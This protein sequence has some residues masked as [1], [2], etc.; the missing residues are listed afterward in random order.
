MKIARKT[1][2]PRILALAISAM[3]SA[4]TNWS[5]TMTTTRSSVN[6]NAWLKFVSLNIVRNGDSVQS[7]PIRKASSNACTI[8]HAKKRPR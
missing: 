8:G 7:S 2:R 3:T 5:G 1:P 6:V 4:S